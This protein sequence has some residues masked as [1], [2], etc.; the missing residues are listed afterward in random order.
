LLC[1]SIGNSDLL[2][3]VKKGDAVDVAKVVSGLD[4][5][6]IVK[7]NKFLST[8]HAEVYYP[9]S[10]RSVKSRLYRSCAQTTSAPQQ[11]RIFF[12]TL[13]IV[14]GKHYQPGTLLRANLLLNNLT[15]L[16]L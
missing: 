14:T 13:E 10:S 12:H 4:K 7:Y 5:L 15:R 1:H 9:P 11:Q 16:K 2:K 3:R 8:H 6:E